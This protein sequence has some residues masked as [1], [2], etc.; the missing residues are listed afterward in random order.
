MEYLTKSEIYE[1]YKTRIEKY[2]NSIAD[3]YKNGDELSII[4][5]LTGKIIHNEDLS[6]RNLAFIPMQVNSKIKITNIE[7]IDI[8]GKCLPK[9]KTY[10]RYNKLQGII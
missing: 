10:I 9:N 8:I 6:D 3:K 4:T 2:P 5:V 1:L 7:H